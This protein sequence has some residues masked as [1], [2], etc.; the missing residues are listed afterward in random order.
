ME[1]GSGVTYAEKRV[2]RRWLK[3]TLPEAYLGN[4][5]FWDFLGEDQNQ[6]DPRDE[7]KSKVPAATGEISDYRDPWRVT[8]AASLAMA[9]GES[10]QIL[11]LL[12]LDESSWFWEGYEDV[13]LGAWDLKPGDREE[14][15]YWCQ[16]AAAITGIKYFTHHTLHAPLRWLIVQ[17]ELSTTI[18]SPIYH[19]V[20]VAYSN[21]ALEGR[22]ASRIDPNE[23]LS[24]SLKHTEGR[25]H[26]D[27]D[28]N[29]PHRDLPLQVA[30]IDDHGGWSIWNVTGD[31]HTATGTLRPTLYRRGV[32]WEGL[33][34]EQ[35]GGF[36]LLWYHPPPGF[37]QRTTGSDDMENAAALLGVASVLPR[38]S[39]TLLM[40]NYTTIQVLNA[41]VGHIASYVAITQRSLNKDKIL[42]VQPNPSDPSQALVLTTHSML[43][44]DICPGG[45][46]AQAEPQVT[47]AYLHDH[48]GNPT[49]QFSASSC[50]RDRSA[51]L[52]LIYPKDGPRVSIFWFYRGAR[53][54]P[55]QFSHQL[56]YFRREDGPELNSFP[57]L[58][59][60]PMRM[61]SY[62]KKAAHGPG[63]MY[64]DLN[65]E[66]HQV[67]FIGRRQSMGYWT[68]ATVNRGA[69]KLLAPEPW[70]TV[71][72]PEDRNPAVVK[73]IKRRAAYVNYM[74]DKF[75]V[76]DALEDADSLAAPQGEWEIWDENPWLEFEPLPTVKRQI[77][78]KRRF[79]P[80][81][82][83]E[84]YRALLS[85]VEPLRVGSLETIRQ[86]LDAGLRLEG[87]PRRSLSVLWYGMVRDTSR[88]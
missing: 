78:V 19:S 27:V 68:C 63:S 86:M 60:L 11:R 7:T 29:P 77:L 69:D 40:W 30:I 36:G 61:A 52:V 24:F 65:V 82:A 12:H 81:V 4:T 84:A 57:T 76:P 72:G 55:G 25:A 47:H 33:P 51:A 54:G 31:L 2:Q 56:Q 50:M 80:H 15:A 5:V 46:N 66:F 71:R 75:V 43:C 26:V 88:G 22:S 53:G 35:R 59:A 28:I 58:C 23:L 6:P 85:G 20:P 9:T 18:L 39:R 79:Y 37:A 8:G 42:Q 21:A 14:E 74:A 3:N 73:Q 16:G 13:N 83:L 45:E 64:R 17:K 34:D 87:V 49:L 41:D 32:F 10:G 1:G 67:V 38:R 70:T 44:L 62:N 48:P